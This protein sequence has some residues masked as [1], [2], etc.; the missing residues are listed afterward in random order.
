MNSKF[1][2]TLVAHDKNTRSEILNSC[3]SKGIIR[4][5]L[6]ISIMKGKC[7]DIE[8]LPY[9]KHTYFLLTNRAFY[10][11]NGEKISLSVLRLARSE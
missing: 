1:H 5:E 8:C 2:V 7:I 10:V 3:F 11:V 4:L 6:G 9:R